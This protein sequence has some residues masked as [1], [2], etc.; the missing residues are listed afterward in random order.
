MHMHITWQVQNYVLKLVGCYRFMYAL[1]T[2]QVPEIG[3]FITRSDEKKELKA[4]NAV[5][6]WKIIK[7]YQ[8]FGKNKEMP[9]ETCLKPNYSRHIQKQNLR[10]WVLNLVTSILYSLPKAR[11][12]PF[13]KAY[14][15]I[16]LFNHKSY[17]RTS[18]K[19]HMM[20]LNNAEEW[21]IDQSFV[22]PFQ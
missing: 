3:Y 8:E 7:I 22:Y 2:D 10:F 16:F 11:R 13:L 18:W 9:S 1:V 5:L 19:R 15:L 4:S 12:W 21:N 14:F 17:F 20:F 6:L